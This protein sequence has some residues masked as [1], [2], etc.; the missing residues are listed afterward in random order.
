MYDSINLTETFIL[1]MSRSIQDLLRENAQELITVVNTLDPTIIMLRP[2][3][4]QWSIIEIC[5]HLISTDFGILGLLS[6][7]GVAAPPDRDSKLESIKKLGPDRTR[8]AKAPAMLQPKGKTDTKDKFDSNIT[9]LREKMAN[10]SQ[11]KDLSQVCSFPHFVFG[12]LTFEE[13]LHFSIGHANRH[14]QQIKEYEKILSA[15]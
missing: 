7:E 12:E 4:D 14:K 11:Q 10:I 15:T 5:D 9:S 8:K 3:P 1:I 13:W 6:S 2:N